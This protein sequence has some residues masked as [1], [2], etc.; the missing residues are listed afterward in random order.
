MKSIEFYKNLYSVRLTTLKSY[1][2]S[3]TNY[4]IIAATNEL[5]YF[6]FDSP[7]ITD[8]FYTKTKERVTFHVNSRSFIDNEGVPL[9][10]WKKLIPIDDTNIAVLSR[11]EFLR[12]IAIYYNGKPFKVIEIIKFYSFVRGGI[13]LNSKQREYQE[14]QDAFNTLLLDDAISSL[15]I[16]MLDIIDICIE[17]I[18]N[19]Y[20]NVLKQ[21]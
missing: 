21:L 10:L 12:F 14:L 15:D 16:T 2:S 1:Q 6:L 13:H 9:F 3:N 18:E 11:D 19:Y 5:R 7:N 8:M 4:S 20:E 17:G